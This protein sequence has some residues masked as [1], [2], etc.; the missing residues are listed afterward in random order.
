MKQLSLALLIMLSLT[1]CKNETNTK[2]ETTKGIDYSKEKLD[3]TT[4]IYPEN[5]TKVF[6]AHGGIDLWKLMKSLEY[7]QTKPDGKEVTITNLVNRKALI[8]ATNYSIG[9]DGKQPWLLNKTNQAYKG[10]D[11]KFGYNLMFYFYAMPFIMSDD[12]I[13]YSETEP[14]VFEGVTYPG[15]KITYQS[16]VGET[17]EDQYLLFYNPE[18]YIMEWLGYTVNFVPGIDTKEFHFRR[19]N[20]WQEVNGLLVP[21]SITGYGYKNDKPTTPKAPNVFTDVKINKVAPN[22]SLFEKP[23]K[24]NYV[25]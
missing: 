10:Y 23:E 7:T 1:S 12:G 25:D 8:D 24:A 9:F 15:I 5:L 3:V 20:D 22:N 17:P 14:L 11:P 2:T 18:T 13:D 4:S 21:K 16:G 19:Y 6:N